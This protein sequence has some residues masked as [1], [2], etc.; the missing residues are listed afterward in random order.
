MNKKDAPKL[1]SF[2]C[3]YKMVHI[4]YDTYDYN[5][6]RVVV[7]KNVRSINGNLIDKNKNWV[8]TSFDNNI[9]KSKKTSTATIATPN[10]NEG[11]RAVTPDVSI[12]KDKNNLFSD[13]TRTKEFK[14]WFGDWEKTIKFANSFIQ[15]KNKYNGKEYTTTDDF[16]RVQEESRSLLPKEISEYHSGILPQDY[17][18][19]IRRGL[20][21]V[22]AGLL[23]RRTSS[24]LGRW[25]LTTVLKGKY[26]AEFRIGGVNPKLF[27]DIFE[28]NRNYLENGELVDLHDDYSECKCFITDDGLA[29]FAI[30]PD[31]NL[32]S[33]FSLNPSDK[34]GFLYAIKDFIREEGATHLDCY[35]SNR[36]NLELNLYMLK[37]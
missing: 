13:N 22:Y 24:S 27:H 1:A 16:R 23:S 6:K 26:D 5:G 36:Q 9:P 17:T 37:L 28:V 11:S 4:I 18:D 2:Y 20:G 35:N 3:I 7:R 29:G 32:I 31:G 25:S 12:G 14:E 21:R 33:S 15:F 34:K 10:G 8:V 30:E 19:T